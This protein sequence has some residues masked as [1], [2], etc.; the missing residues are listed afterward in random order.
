MQRIPCLLLFILLAP[1]LSLAAM[2]QR[3][4]LTPQ[5]TAVTVYQDR[6]QTVRSATLNLAAGTH[7]VALEGL[8][9]L[10][11]DDSIR[12]EGSGTARGTITGVEVKR[13][14]LPQTAE[15]QARQLE[16][17][18]RVLE[19][20]LGGL[21]AKKSGLNAQKNFLES[22]RVAWGDRLSKELAIGKPTSAELQ[23]AAGFVA[24]NITKVE[25]QL[26]DLASDRQQVT[27]KID[28]L[29]R[30][31]REATGSLRK[32]LKT[33]EVA[34]E[35]TRGGSFTFNLSGMVSRARWEPAYDVRLLPDGTSAQ[36]T[37]RA[38]VRQQTGEDWRNVAL[39]LSTAR[40]SSGGAPPELKPWRIAFWRPPPPMPAPAARLYESRAKSAM[41]ELSDKALAE[42]PDEG[43]EEAPAAVQTAQL[44]SETTSVSFAIPQPVDV[45]G[46]GSLQSSV[47]AITTLPVSTDY[48]AVPKLS[49][50]VYLSAELVN[51]AAYPLLPGPI[52]IFTGNTFT[53][54]A[55]MKQ[56][57]SGEKFTLPFGSDDQLT[58]TREELK[59]H[60]EAGLFSKNRMGYRYKLE[61][62]NFR[63]QPQTLNIKEQLPLAG[64]NEIT[65]N[66][67]NATL[68]PNEKK[69]D[70]TLIWK[71]KLGPG[72]KKELSYE[73]VVEYPKDREVSG[74]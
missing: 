62:T 21:D 2:P 30:Q 60:K 8:P 27:E 24:S 58:V 19:R 65:V 37:Y 12:V 57:A 69:E 18:I 33:A 67:V 29:Q 53:G 46:D 71:L 17:E 61:A 64:D 20:K 56:V 45:A 49:P 23:D 39:T 74:L 63:K 72:E 31:L 26:F 32:E 51:Q 52:R 40:P 47:I 38:Q 4:T 42:A 15:Q 7:V 48:L 3:S 9:V 13:R 54:S 10:L 16:D 43:P 59:Q 1:A 66:L 70:G 5:L 44:A 11:Q 55:T 28:A 35:V 6:A 22:I 41:M 73:I 68:A 25:E 34:L 36:L 14:F 50:T